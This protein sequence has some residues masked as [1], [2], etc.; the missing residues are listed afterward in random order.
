MWPRLPR[1]DDRGGCAAEWVKDPYVLAR[2][3]PGSA[4]TAG[5]ARSPGVFHVTWTPRCSPARAGDRR[6]GPRP[7]PRGRGRSVG[8]RGSRRSDRHERRCARCGP[9]LEHR[10]GR[11]VAVSTPAGTTQY[12]YDEAG[13]L[14][15]RV[16][17]ATTGFV[18][19]NDYDVA[20]RLVARSSAAGSVLL[21]DVR[22]TLDEVGNP[23]ALK[24]RS[25][26]QTMQYDTR[27]R[28]VEWCPDKS[29]TSRESYTYDAVGNR[30]KVQ[31]GR[32][33][34]ST[35]FDASDRPTDKRHRPSTRTATRQRWV[36]AR[37]ATTWLTG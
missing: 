26:E 9:S 31:R 6:C 20:G 5:H 14:V 16:L 21:Q 15:E 8:R 28:L 2:S 12:R 7:W 10:S 27:N 35:D 25:S 3:A 30:V 34:S 37:R 36:A 11:V 33:T 18:E 17:P 24:S 23:V 32:S 4:R 29:C 13:A 22:A 19:S 1:D